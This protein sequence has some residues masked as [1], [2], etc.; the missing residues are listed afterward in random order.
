MSVALFED[1]PN[2]MSNVKTS[3]LDLF[4][5]ELDLNNVYTEALNLHTAKC[6]IEALELTSVPKEITI[7]FLFSGEKPDCEFNICKLLS[8]NKDIKKKYI[9][10][11]N[12]NRF[13]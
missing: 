5:K 8:H 4:S 11:Y 12:I 1:K 7:I 2:K 3:G 13:I 9:L 10:Q 6:I